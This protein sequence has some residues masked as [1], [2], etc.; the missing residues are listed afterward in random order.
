MAIAFDAS[1][2]GT[3]F[4][5]SGS[6]LAWSHTCTGSDRIL[7]VSLT[8]YH[9]SVSGG[10]IVSGVTYN[11]V[12]MTLLG[13]DDAQTN[14]QFYIFYLVA[15]A[16]GSNTI[17]ASFSS[18]TTF[19]W[20]VSGSYTGVDQTSPI[21]SSAFDAAGQT[22]RSLIT[23]T[24]TVVASNCWTV[25]GFFSNGGGITANTG[26][27]RQLS[28]TSDRQALVDSN[29]TVATGSQSLSVNCNNDNT[30]WGILSLAEAGAG[31]GGAVVP[32]P[33]LSLLGVG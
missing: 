32:V 12:S 31:G 10:D 28:P 20:G 3:R 15:P 29:G 7:I 27:L 8:T 4:N 11:G 33:T 2:G 13:K 5:V 17:T 1:A 14:E 18:S 21:D 30:S 26:T 9:P 24:T 16:T 25:A 23:A 19:A 22:A 6:S